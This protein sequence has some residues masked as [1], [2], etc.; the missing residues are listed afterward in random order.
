MGDRN[1]RH[2][3]DITVVFHKVDG[4]SHDDNESGNYGGGDDE[5][6]LERVHLRGSYRDGDAPI[7]AREEEEEEEEGEGAREERRFCPRAL[8]VSREPPSQG[9]SARDGKNTA[10]ARVCMTTDLRRAQ[11]CFLIF[12]SPTSSPLSR[13]TLH[14]NGS[15]L[16]IEETGS[17]LQRRYTTVM[18]WL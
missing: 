16:Q 12:T 9:E 8:C 6:T 7:P 17:Y 10:H 4:D 11:T 18:Y 14:N 5:R 3:D 15:V 1:H 13:R 2:E